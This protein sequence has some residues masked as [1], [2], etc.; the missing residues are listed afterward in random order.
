[1]A[2]GDALLILSCNTSDSECCPFGQKDFRSDFGLV[3]SSLLALCF[4]FVFLFR[5]ASCS[6]LRTTICQTPSCASTSAFNFPI[7]YPIVR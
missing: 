2:N 6:G 3:T 5:S 7:D 1:M 4:F